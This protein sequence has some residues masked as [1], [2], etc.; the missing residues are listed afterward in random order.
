MRQLVTL[1]FVLAAIDLS[2]DTLT[3][4][5]AAVGRLSAKQPVRATFTTEALV[6]ASGRFANDNTKRKASVEVAHDP[7]GV[8]ISIPSAMLERAEKQ[9]QDLIGSIRTIPIVDALDFRRRM[10]ELLE[11]A[12]LIEEKPSTFAGKPARLLVLKLT[13]PPK[14]ESNSIRI[15]SVKS[16][17]R[18]SLWIGPDSLPLAAERNEKS[19]AGI[20]MFRASGVSRT[21]YTFATTDDRLILAREESEDSGSALGQNVQ[22]NGVQTLTLR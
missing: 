15:G 20:M 16:E 14:K 13:P 5:K 18:M 7:S 12:N 9:G 6:K 8:T 11:Y 19:S 10:L 3:D 2:A 22:R 17:E 21:K 1:L 4:V